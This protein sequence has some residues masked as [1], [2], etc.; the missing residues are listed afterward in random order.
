MN[1]K[2]SIH[3]IVLSIIV[4]VSLYFSLSLLINLD[5]TF[6]LVNFMRIKA[7]QKVSADI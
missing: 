4:A 6:I 2:R 3:I 1:K 7:S 5:I